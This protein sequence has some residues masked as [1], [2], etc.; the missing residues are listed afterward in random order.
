M[1]SCHYDFSGFEQQPGGTVKALNAG[2]VC[3]KEGDS[4]LLKGTACNL[5]LAP[6]PLN[7]T[8]ESAGYG[9]SSEVYLNMITSNIK[10]TSSN[11]IGC[12]IAGVKPSGEDGVMNQQVTLRGTLPG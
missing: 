4:I 8:F 3:A 12:K 2:I 5:Y 10:Y 6:Q 9:V 7:G 1:N 11:G